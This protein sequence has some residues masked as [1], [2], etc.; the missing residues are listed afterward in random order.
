MN[1]Y[2]GKSGEARSWKPRQPGYES[3]GESVAPLSP[4]D[5]WTLYALKGQEHQTEEGRPKSI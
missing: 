5:D 2:K 4:G 1:F 3:E